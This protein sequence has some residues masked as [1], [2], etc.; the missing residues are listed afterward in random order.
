MALGS[1]QP[2]EKM[3]T[4]NI[5]GGKGGQCVRLTSPPSHAE[6]HEIW[7]SKPPGTLWATPGLLQDLYNTSQYSMTT[8]FSASMCSQ[9]IQHF[10]SSQILRYENV[11]YA[12]KILQYLQGIPTIM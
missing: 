12:C 7:E 1:T 11:K 2:L 3:S 4:R 10:N 5:P 9:I 6:C 8:S